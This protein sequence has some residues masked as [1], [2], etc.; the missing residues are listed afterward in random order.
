MTILIAQND[1]RAMLEWLANATQRGGTFISCIARAGLHADT[2]NY[3]LMRP[4]LLVLRKK[5]PEYEPSEDVKRE[6]GES[7]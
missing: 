1:D 4:L 2:E 5:Y 7:A 6:I 3:P